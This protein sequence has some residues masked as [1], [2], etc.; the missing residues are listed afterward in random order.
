[1]CFFNLL[2]LYAIVMFTFHFISMKDF[3]L[4]FH[5]SSFFFL[6]CFVDIL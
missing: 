2:D 6:S 1:M 3:I 4:F 5:F